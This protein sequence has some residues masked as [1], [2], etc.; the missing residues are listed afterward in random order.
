[1]DALIPAA[2]AVNFLC[3]MLLLGETFFVLLVAPS[4]PGARAAGARRTSPRTLGV[5]ACSLAGG[6]VSAIAWLAAE[7]VVM[8]GL[9]VRRALDRGTMSVVLGETTFGRVWLFRFA[10]AIAFAIVLFALARVPSGRHARRLST[11]ALVVAAGYLCAL[12]WSG[13]AGASAGPQRAVHLASDAL[14]LLAAGLWLGALPALL[15]LLGG[16]PPPLV[17]A[18]RAV[19]RFST[20]GLTAV[21]VLIASGAVNAWFLVGSIPALFETDYGRLLLV[22]LVFVAAMVSLAAVNRMV[23]TPRLAYPDGGAMRLLRRNAVLEIAIGIAVV[24]VVAVLGITVPATHQSRDQASASPSE[25][26]MH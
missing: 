10:L 5:L 3:A 9:A 2:R 24:S 15:R 23:L 26:H 19:G 14:H 21:V 22:K 20:L 13:H 6:V 25:R 7:A 1:M 16:S 11:V 18:V 4:S 8:S 17:D 12:A